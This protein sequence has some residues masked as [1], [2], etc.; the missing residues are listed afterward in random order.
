MFNVHHI[1]FLSSKAPKL[2]SFLKKKNIYFKN[3]VQ[4]LGCWRCLME[5]ILDTPFATCKS[6]QLHFLPGISGS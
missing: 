6:R 3:L 1:I 4:N 5:S 2:I